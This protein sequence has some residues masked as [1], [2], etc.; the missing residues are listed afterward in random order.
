[1][2]TLH[3]SGWEIGTLAVHIEFNIKNVCEVKELS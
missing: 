1:M 2:K 3:P